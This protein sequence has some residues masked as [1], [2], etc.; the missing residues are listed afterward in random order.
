LLFLA[1]ADADALLP[2]LTTFDLRTWLCEHLAGR[3]HHPRTNDVHL[4]LTH[5]DECRVEVQGAL[6]AHLIDNLLDN[7]C[8]YSA[9]G[10]EIVLRVKAEPRGVVLSIEDRGCG[11]AD[12]EL[13]HVFEPFY[14]SPRAREAGLSGTGLGLAVA[15]RI[16]TAMG[17]HV[18][19][20]SQLGQGSCFRLYLPRADPGLRN[21]SRKRSSYSLNTPR[22]SNSRLSS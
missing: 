10:S 15:A 11:I 12:D 1:R 9:P 14:R 13:P 21:R 18:D 2:D 17:G 19:V 7:A 6:L 5:C 22:R 8:K 20:E 4:D 3:Q 16:A